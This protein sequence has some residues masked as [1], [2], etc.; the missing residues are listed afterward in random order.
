MIRWRVADVIISLS[1]DRDDMSLGNFERVCGFD[2]EWKLLRR[3]AKHC[4]PNFAPL[5]ANGNLGANRSNV[6]PGGIY[7]RDVNVAV[8]FHFCVNDAASESIPLFL[9]LTGR[10]LA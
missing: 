7:K 10:G 4:L 3:P 6:V 2:A 8:C 1:G 9:G 5:R